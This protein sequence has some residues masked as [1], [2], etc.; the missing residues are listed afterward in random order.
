MRNSFGL[1]RL[2]ARPASDVWHARTSVELCAVEPRST[3]TVRLNAAGL[4]FGDVAGLAL[5][6]AV[7]LVPDH[8]GSGLSEDRAPFNTHFAGRTTRPFGWL[9]VERGRDGFTLAQFVEHSGQTGRVPLGH[10]P[11]WLRAECDFVRNRVGFS[12]ST[13]GADYVGI[14]EPQPMGDRPG[15]ALVMWCSL[16]ACA[17]NGRADGGHADFDS[18][19]LSTARLPGARLGPGQ[20]SP[21]GRARGR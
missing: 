9:G 12:C 5:V 14:G 15:A 19:L 16:F 2:H 18:L 6:S 13:D 8:H 4:L 20:S 7:A 10:R 17:T 3:A 21:A 1:I 11:V